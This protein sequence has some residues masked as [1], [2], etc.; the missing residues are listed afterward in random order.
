MTPPSR[1]TSSIT[2]K[3][4]NS[5]ADLIKKVSYVSQLKRRIH[6]S[7]LVNWSGQSGRQRF[8]NMS[9][10]SNQCSTFKAVFLR[11]KL[12]I[13]TLRFRQATCDLIYNLRFYNGKHI[14][15]ASP[16]EQVTSYKEHC[17]RWLQICLVQFILI[18]EHKAMEP[19][20]WPVFFKR[21][22]KDL[23]NQKYVFLIN[24]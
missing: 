9:S 4:T 13:P 19:T 2:V 6:L 10:W 5:I 3:K 20:T 1:S 17:N 22:N 14:Y 7:S 16:S 21:L 18:P 11:R 23:K 12:D 15:F 24:Y 8:A